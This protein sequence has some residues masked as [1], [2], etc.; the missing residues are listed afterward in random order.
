[1]EA[2]HDSVPVVNKR[3]PISRQKS[4]QFRVI[5][6]EHRG[7]V[8]TFPEVEGLRPTPDRVRETLFNWLQL[9]IAGASCLDLFA[10]SGALSIEA[11][12]RGASQVLSVEL[13]SDAIN[14]LKNNL[15]KLELDNI[16]T[17]QSDALSWL[18]QVKESESFDIIFLDPP[19]S[20]KLLPELISKIEEQGLLAEQG[21]VYLENNS[22]LEELELPDDWLLKKSKKAGQVY[23]GICQKTD[24]S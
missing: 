6:G 8:L 1:M 11:C 19:Y 23:F 9:S 16:N 13:S 10:G 22:P 14:S 5:A 3:P 24:C 20:L 7:R 21:F 4:N 18:N 12:S 15:E 17:L 2:T